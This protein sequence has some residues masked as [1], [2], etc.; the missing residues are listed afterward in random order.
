VYKRQADA[1]ADYTAAIAAATSDHDRLAAY[2]TRREFYMAM[3]RTEEARKD[4]LRYVE[5]AATVSDQ[6]GNPFRAIPH[7]NNLALGYL[8]M[9]RLA[10]AISLFEQV[11]ERFKSEAGPDHPRTY[12]SIINLAVGYAMAGRATEAVPLLER[13]LARQRAKPGP[14]HPDTLRTMVELAWSYSLVSRPAEAVLLLEHVIEQRKAKLGPDAHP[15]LHAMYALAIVYQDA[16]RLDHADRLL[17]DLIERRRKGYPQSAVTADALSR[18]G[19]NLL[20]QG[21]YAEAESLLGECLAIRAEKEPD[22]WSRFDALSL[23]GGS[24]VG[25]G[26]YAE[27][28]PPLLQGYDGLKQ[29]EANIRPSRKVCLQE[30]AER[31]VRLYEATGQADKARAW[32]EKLPAGERRGG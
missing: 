12:A 17:R 3:G 1:E 6:S 32:R 26:K 14:N 11:V 9:G 22:D 28:E 25:Q 5:Y 24:L 16:G 10:E 27:A 15:T 7:M 23:L 2:I 29:R 19:Q 4:I 21:R 31:L 13:V 18:L 20:K 8:D 30:A